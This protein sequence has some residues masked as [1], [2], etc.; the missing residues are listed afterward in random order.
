MVITQFL[1][2]QSLPD[3]A[4]NLFLRF[5]S[6]FVFSSFLF[7]LSTTFFILYAYSIIGIEA[8]GIVI[9]IR[10]AIQLIF[11]YPSGSLGD[12]IG[13]KWV[14]T[15][16]LVCSAVYL[17][18]LTIVD[19][20]VDPFPMFVFIAVIWGFSDAQASGTLN[21]WFDSNYQLAID[22]EDSE[23]KIYGFGLNRTISLSRIVMALAFIIGGFMATNF[24][25]QSVFLLQSILC[26]VSILLV[27]TL[28]NDIQSDK[29]DTS[30]QSMK[31]YFSLF[32]GGILFLF[33]SKKAFFFLMGIALISTCFI[34]WWELI[35][36]P[37]YF[38]Y[39]GSDDLAS[40]FRTIMFIIGIPI[41]IY[42]AKI[43][44]KISTE[45]VSFLYIIGI[46]FY[47]I[48]FIILLSLLPPLDVFNIVG[49]AFTAFILTIA[50]NIL[51]DVA[52]T[53]QGRAM[54]DLVPS[55]N[56]NAVYSLI[57]SLFSLMGIPLLPIT[58]SLIKNYG[59]NI[60]II[61]P[62]SVG[63]IGSLFILLSFIFKEKTL[64]QES[65]F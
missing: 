5:T 60:G 11:D 14:F 53:L 38:G 51:L 10:L 23:R 18:L 39:S 57:P 8:A 24:A 4:Q 26:L 19:S 48:P 6:L 32:K 54:I 35:L 9:A 40:L 22:N 1:G 65:D 25:R 64:S 15:L 46:L 7:N 52:G 61:I 56:R 13:Q 63:F 29:K 62:F 59:L 47:N 45:R 34:I 55:E 20:F 21:S 42:M 49:L 2:I 36:F 17:Y 43:T 44:Q 58:G 16:S 37:V 27:Q 33:S 12:W 31:Q 3:T 30:K 50:N 41:G 28:M